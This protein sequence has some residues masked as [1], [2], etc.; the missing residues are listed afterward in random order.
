MTEAPRKRGYK[1]GYRNTPL[2]ADP[3][4]MSE[5]RAAWVKTYQDQFV[6]FFDLVKEGEDAGHLKDIMFFHSHDGG[7]SASL[8]L[9]ACT[10]DELNAIEEFWMHAISLARPIV[11]HRDKEARDA[12]E[13]GD[14]TY[15]RNYRALPVRVYRKGPVP[16]YGEGVQH[17]SSDAADVG[18]DGGDHEGR[19]RDQGPDVA[20]RDAEG[21][22]P[23]DDGATA[24]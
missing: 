12:L 4:R 9:T 22:G 23:Q 15:M 1:M 5:G 11:Q 17:G 7:R 8:N 10:E 24:D 6:I 16:E 13:A 18:G 21:R 20:E 3:A 19:V 2:H 14:D